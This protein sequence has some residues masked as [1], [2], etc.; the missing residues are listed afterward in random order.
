M[1]KKVYSIDDLM[2]L[3][4]IG[5]RVTFWRKRKQGVIPEPDIKIGHP[6]W[7]R[8]TLEKHLPNLPEM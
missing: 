3:L 8:G 2:E 5:S 6:R 7:F 4:G 1:M